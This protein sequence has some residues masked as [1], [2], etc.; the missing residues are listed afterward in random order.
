LSSGLAA[1]SLILV[2]AGIEGGKGPTGVIEQ[3][4]KKMC[5][6][7]FRSLLFIGIH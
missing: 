4:L 6:Y 7:F 1:V 5:F 3:G 2:V